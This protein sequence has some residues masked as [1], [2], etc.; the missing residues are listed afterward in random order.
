MGEKT[1]F[2]VGDKVRIRTW[3]DMEKEFGVDGD[4]DIKCYKLFVKNMKHLC[5]RLATIT[6]FKGENILL[7]FDDTTG[8]TDWKYS[9]DMIEPV[10]QTIV[11]YRK[12]QEVIALD[13]STGNKAVA[14][15]SPDDTFDFETGAKLAFERLYAPKVKEVKR[16]AKVGEYIKIV[17]A[18]NVPKTNGKPDYKNGDILKVLKVTN[19][20]GQV[21]YSEAKTDGF[22]GKF[23]NKEEYVV[24]E[25]YEPPTEEKKD[26]FLHEFKNGKTYVFRKSIFERRMMYSGEWTKKVNGK[27][28]E[29]KNKKDGRCD[30]YDVSPEWCEELPFT[31]RDK[32]KV[33]DVG[34]TYDS[35]YDWKGLGDYKQNFVEYK[36]PS[37]NKTYKILNIANHNDNCDIMALI[38]DTDTTQVF[39]IGIKGIEKV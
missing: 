36:D 25:G 11:I 13:K 15:C 30:L 35:Y 33:I 38:Q 5:G 8:K 20:N 18:Y 31:I 10:N 37:L 32:V 21:K 34:E 14:K 16:K 24:L 27:I 29:V 17:D 7:D 23:V 4:G 26:E 6:G 22:I 12:G 1:K 2:K 39:I 9:A 28:V 3:E 19:E